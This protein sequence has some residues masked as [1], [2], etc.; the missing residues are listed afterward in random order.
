MLG[1]LDRLLFNIHF[2]LLLHSLFFPPPLGQGDLLSG[3]E[4]IQR[5]ADAQ[6][7]H[8]AHEAA[9]TDSSRTALPRKRTDGTR[10]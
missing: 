2:F 1:L 6:P 4:G 10:W 5:E 8:E 7:R 9:S 3:S